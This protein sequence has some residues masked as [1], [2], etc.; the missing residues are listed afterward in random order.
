VRHR[1]DQAVELRTVVG[2]VKLATSYGQDRK[3]GHWGNPIRERW[4]LSPNQELSPAL[5]EKAAFT[6]TATHTYQ[7]AAEVSC[8]WGSPLSDSTVHRLTQRL[9]A[10]AEAQTQ[11]RL[12]EV[13]QEAEPQR[14]PSELG[15]LML[16]GWLARFR[17]EGWGQEEP[18]DKKRVEWHEIKNGL[19]YR[20]EQAGRTAG[21]RGVISEKVL[22]RW[23]GPPVEL[24]QRLHWEALRAGLGRAQAME[25]VGDGI[26]W[27]WNLKADRW[28][29]ATEVLD[30]WHGAEHLWE[31]G[32]AYVGQ[33]E[34][35]VKPW[36]ESRL[37]QLRHGEEAVVLKEVASLKS[38]RGKR[39][40]SLNEQK[41][42]FA[43]QAPRMHYQEIADR[44]WPIG[45][46]AVESSCLGSQC[47]FKRP[48]QF[49]T[50]NGLRHLSAL[51]EARANDHWDQLWNS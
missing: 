27:I 41:R 11:Q 44:G 12:K 36:V 33:D 46:G 29:E 6:V 38:P 18:S 17:A 37:H 9:G 32:R 39:G 43:G 31:L 16:D 35:Q 1:H 48:G 5:E 51:Q 21:D 3:D 7:A 2:V 14:A 50:K 49:W 34:A 47:R 23:Q 28:K 40:Q 24:G 25:V 42:Y 22:V 19:F 4:G 45:S 8:K 30:F 10:T 26:E 15:V 13:P 20:L